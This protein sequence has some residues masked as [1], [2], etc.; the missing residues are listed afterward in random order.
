MYI[1]LDID[2]DIEIDIEIDRQDGMRWDGIGQDRQIALYLH[3]MG[4]W[5]LM[6]FDL[7][8]FK[9]NFEPYKYSQCSVI[10]Q[11]AIC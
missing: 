6:G 7:M 9:Y 5:A 11:N 3:V 8:V 2:I 4:Q 1:D 10:E